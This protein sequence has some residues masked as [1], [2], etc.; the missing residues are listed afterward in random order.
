MGRPDRPGRGRLGGRRRAG[1]QRLRRCTPEDDD[2]SQAGTLVREVFDDAQRDR[3][4]ETVADHLSKGV[5]EPVLS[6]AFQY[7][8]NIDET[9]GERIEKRYHEIK[10]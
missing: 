10:K 6:R 7:W 2:F 1:A 4:A 8:R 3:L 5:V 9:I